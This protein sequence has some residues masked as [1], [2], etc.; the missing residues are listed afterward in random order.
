MLLTQNSLLFRLEGF[1]CWNS[2]ILQHP[3]QLLHTA[4]KLLSQFLCISGKQKKTECIPEVFNSDTHQCECFYPVHWNTCIM[5]YKRTS[6][7]KANLHSLI[8]ISKGIFF[9][10]VETWWVNTAM[11]KFLPA[12]NQ[13]WWIFCG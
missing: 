7:W 10:F 5:D 8:C 13:Q 2:T 9:L 12:T 6:F 3:L 1:Q 4:T 11:E